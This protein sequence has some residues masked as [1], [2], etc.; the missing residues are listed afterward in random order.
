MGLS[1]G[2]AAM[3][4]QHVHA[5]PHGL[6]HQHQDQVVQQGRIPLGW[7]HCLYGRT[8]L[9]ARAHTCDLASLQ[10]VLRHVGWFTRPMLAEK[11]TVLC[12]F[13]NCGSLAIQASMLRA[14]AEH[15]LLMGLPHL[16]ASIVVRYPVHHLVAQPP[17]LQ[18]VKANKES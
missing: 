5:N 15:L 9:N 4:S 7:E 17:E 1:T 10:Q 2:L 3:P 8:H 13:V 6:L 14:H 12:T 11:C 16:E 18:V